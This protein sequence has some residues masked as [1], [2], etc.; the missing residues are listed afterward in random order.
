MPAATLPAVA[1]CGFWALLQEM[2][3]GF[4]MVSGLLGGF[5][6]ALRGID[7][8]DL[9]KRWSCVAFRAEST[10]KTA[11]KLRAGSAGFALIAFWLVRFVDSRT[12]AFSFVIQ[13]TCEQGMGGAFGCWARIQRRHRLRCHQGRACPRSQR[14]QV[15]RGCRRARDGGGMFRRAPDLPGEFEQRAEGRLGARPPFAEPFP[16]HTFVPCSRVEALT[17]PLRTK[18]LVS[19]L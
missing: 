16:E 3:A 11:Q 9:G 19:T 13:R 17:S 10:C 7:S 14:T 12:S 1:P 15:N 4:A 18:T 5:R 6:G 2:G 8:D